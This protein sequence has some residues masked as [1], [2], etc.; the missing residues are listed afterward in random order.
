MFLAKLNPRALQERGEFE[1]AYADFTE[2][3]KALTQLTAGA[4]PFRM[5]SPRLAC[6][7]R[8]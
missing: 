5:A 3:L 8:S 6:W 2:T 4:L 7:H 1:M